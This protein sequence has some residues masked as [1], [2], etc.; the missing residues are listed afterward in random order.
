M[1]IVGASSKSYGNTKIAQYLRKRIDSLTGIK[2][3]KQIAREIGYDRPNMLSMMKT[4]ETKVPLEKVPALAEALG[5]DVGHL[6]RLGLEQYW[7]N[8]LDVIHEV[9]GRL[10]TANEWE[11]VQVFRQETRDMDPKI[12]EEQIAKL[13]LLFGRAA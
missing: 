9:F 10:I 8:K 6:M 12:D 1:F 4:G 13:R 5:C 2:S 3:Q 7:P 11:I